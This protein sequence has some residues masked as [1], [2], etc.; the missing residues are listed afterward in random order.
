MKIILEYKQL[1]N[2]VFDFMDAKLKDSGTIKN[3]IEATEKQKELFNFD[4]QKISIKYPPPGQ[5][6]TERELFVWY[7]PAYFSKLGKFPNDMF[8]EQAP[9]LT[10]S[11]IE[12]EQVEDFFGKKAKSYLVDYYKEKFDLGLPIKTIQY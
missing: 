10:I 5:S 8:F 1:K 7:S 12:V 4:Y 2:L 3:Y 11:P 6:F 9:I